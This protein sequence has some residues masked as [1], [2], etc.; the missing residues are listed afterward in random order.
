MAEKNDETPQVDRPD[1]GAG[2]DAPPNNLNEE[3]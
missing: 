3:V 1:Q 2:S